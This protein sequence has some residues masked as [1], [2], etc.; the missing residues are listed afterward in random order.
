MLLELTADWCLP[1]QELA[2]RTFPAPEVVAEAR[3]FVMARV[4]ATERTA[5]VDALF[6]RYG[7]ASLPAVLFFDSKGGLLQEPRI[8]GFVAPGELAR[9]MAAVR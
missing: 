4:D 9:M 8:T 1:C 6:E 7:V 2:R 3:R 5:A